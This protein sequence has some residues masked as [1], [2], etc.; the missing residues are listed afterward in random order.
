MVNYIVET[1]LLAAEDILIG[2]HPK[3]QKRDGRLVEV[4]AVNAST[5]LGVLVVNSKEDLLAIDI[6]LLDT[7]VVYVIKDSTIYKYDGNEWV[8]ETSNIAIIESADDLQHI[9]NGYKI[10][11]NSSEALLYHK[12]LGEPWKAVGTYLYVKQEAEDFDNIPDGINMA[13]V[14]ESGAL[15]HRTIT[16]WTQV[17]LDSE[18]D[19]LIIVE[20]IEDLPSN[21]TLKTAIVNDD[22]RGGIFKFDAAL[23]DLDDGGINIKGWIRQFSG[24]VS[25]LWYGAKGD[26]TTDNSDAFQR[27]F[28]NNA[29]IIPYGV[30]KV[31][32][33]VQCR[34]TIYIESSNALIKM[35]E[36]GSFIFSGEAGKAIDIDTPVPIGSSQLQID[37]RQLE[38]GKYIQLIDKQ[39]SFGK[40][41]RNSSQITRVLKKSGSMRVNLYNTLMHTF[42]QPTIIP[43]NSIKVSIEGL[44]ITSISN[45]ATI[46]FMYT[47]NTTLT[48]CNIEAKNSTGVLISKSI[49]VKLQDVNIQAT[50]SGDCYGIKVFNTDNFIVDAGTIYGY[51]SAIKFEKDSGICN[52]IGIY[53]SIIISSVEYSIRIDGNTSGFNIKD[54][55]IT[56]EIQAGGNSF[57]VDN[58]IITSPKACVTLQ[59]MVGGQVSF[60]NVSFIGT[61]AQVSHM[62]ITHSNGSFLL[63]SFDKI[64]K[65]IDYVIR[66]CA[67]ADLTGNYMGIMEA[68]GIP[69]TSSIAPI[70]S[71]VYVENIKYEGNTRTLKNN[72]LFRFWGPFNNVTLKNAYINTEDSIYT[73]CNA[74]KVYENNTTSISQF[75]Y[76]TKY[77]NADNFYSDAI[78]FS[79]ASVSNSPDSNY[80]FRLTI[81]NTS[82]LINGIIIRGEK[83]LPVY[84]GAQIERLKHNLTEVIYRVVN[85]DAIY[86]VR[87]NNSQGSIGNGAISDFKAQ[88]ARSIRIYDNRVD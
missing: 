58:S 60:N 40:H 5:L 51:K 71:N 50:G 16:G 35:E 31:K 22:D 66:D 7:K 37:N 49:N 12:T 48:N 70:K 72:E 21:P 38:E 27:A 47:D 25:V 82:K 78:V 32:N 23:V 68:I 76:T 39:Q 11:Y 80:H 57:K 6:N 41:G 30:Y 64:S 44:R 84:R 29:V 63:P 75:G 85:E 10:A 77:F 69:A 43:I 55:Q 8:T 45:I 17:V 53:R 3:Q 65:P 46:S 56:G 14:V 52:F 33:T 36:A 59:Y 4:S 34:N 20:T 83:L 26:D 79:V 13:I 86:D 9:P 15:Y 62:F 19:P 87:Y 54:S 24:Q 42:I 2:I 67:F 18:G 81:T 74:K 28:R 1:N 61:S 88:L 73:Q